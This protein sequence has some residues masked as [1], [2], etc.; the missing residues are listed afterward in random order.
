MNIGRLDIH[1]MVQLTGQNLY[2]KKI[3]RDEL[4]FLGFYFFLSV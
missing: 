3:V 4:L 1:Y 2:I